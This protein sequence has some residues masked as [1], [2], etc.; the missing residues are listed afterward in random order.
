MQSKQSYFCFSFCLL[1]HFMQHTILFIFR[2]RLLGQKLTSKH[3]P[4]D[5]KGE[6]EIIMLTK[7][8]FQSSIDT[9]LQALFALFRSS[10]PEVFW[11][12]GVLKI[13]SKLTGEGPCQSVISI[14]LQR[15]FMEIT[16]RHGCSPVNLLHIFRAL[17]LRTP[18][19]GCFC[20]F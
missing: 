20:L 2:S 10:R 3:I 14:K 6:K 18:L 7:S 4:R 12:K 13:C 9:F 19:N 16:L 1:Q 17:L 15:N 11:G 8:R 5:N